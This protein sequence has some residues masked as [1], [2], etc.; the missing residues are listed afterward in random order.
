MK[1]YV[2][3]INFGKEVQE[4]TF[5]SREGALATLDRAK[6]RPHFFD[7]TLETLSNGGDALKPF[8]TDDFEEYDRETGEL[9]SD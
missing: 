7:A 6:T 4:L 9:V 8:Y 5:A 3:N 1:I 2:L